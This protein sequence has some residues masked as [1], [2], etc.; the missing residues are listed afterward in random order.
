M[1]T[2]VAS[3]VLE[4]AQRGTGAV[5]VRAPAAHPDLN[6]AG[7]EVNGDGMAARLAAYVVMVAGRHLSLV[8]LERH[9]AERLPRYRI[10]NGVRALA[11]LP[12]A[13]NG[14]SDRRTLVSDGSR[15][16]Q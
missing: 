6:E 4:A 9:R 15:E 10:L 16:E 2:G 8:E 14:K 3:L 11:A 7:V 1:K 12:R 5:A 13:S